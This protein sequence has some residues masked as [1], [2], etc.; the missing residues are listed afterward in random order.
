VTAPVS[1]AERICVVVSA[2]MTMRTLIAPHIAALQARYAV[3]AIAHLGAGEPPPVGPGVEFVSL[4]IE[5][6]IAPLR[7]LR[8]LTRLAWLFRQS[9]FAAVQS[10][11]PK[12]GLFAMLAGWIARVPVRIHVFTGQVWATRSG[13]ARG[14]L[15]LMDRIIA[16]CATHVLVDSPSQRDFL[17]REGVVSEQKSRVLGKGSIAGVDAERFK[18]DP[19]ARARLRG[20]IGCR[21]GECVFLYLGRLNR[22]KGVLDL[23]AAYTRAA[24]RDEKARLL[25]VGPDEGGL[26]PAMLATL[27]KAAQRATFVSYTDRP[28]DY[29]AAA[30]VLCLPSYREGFGTVIIEAGAC[31]VPAIA[32]RIYGVTDAVEE[33][34][35]GL[36]H[37]PADVGALAGQMSRLARDPALRASLGE[38]ARAKALRDFP[39]SA[40]T[41]ELLNLYAAALGSGR[42]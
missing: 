33:G 8:A 30:D 36:L 17:L 10:V 5:R 6:R 25:V 26:K 4:P 20:E 32:S 24:A 14:F 39:E 15:K 1:V 29:L 18:P 11:T 23:A 16:A 21:N 38:R 13:P 35:T 31:G 42:R 9:Q 40:L 34:V 2:P 28:E 41:A 22:D 7:D 27:G 37:P 12:A 3:T 19:A